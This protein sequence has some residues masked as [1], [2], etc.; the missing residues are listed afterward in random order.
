ML[1]LAVAVV[2][3]A[4]WLI[5]TDSHLTFVADDWGLVVKRRGWR[6]SDF[7]DPFHGS[8]IIGLAFVYRVLQEVFGTGSA[9]PF[10][11]VAIMTFLASAVLLFVFLRLLLI[12]SLA[13]S[14]IGLAFAVGALAAW[15]SAAVRGL[16]GPTSRCCRSRSTPSGGG[17]GPHR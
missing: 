6:A 14:S 1:C 16:G 17:L 8:L 12:V 3:A 4:V 7:L 2:A 13:F 9:T 11:V 5:S 10:Y 15:R